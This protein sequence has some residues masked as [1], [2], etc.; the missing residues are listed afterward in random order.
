MT[1]DFQ[2]TLFITATV[3][4]GAKDPFIALEPTS[5]IPVSF[6]PGSLSLKLKEGTSIE[7]AQRL[8]KAL[9]E[10]VTGITHLPKA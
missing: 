4:E 3:K 9:R 2:E 7:E 5:S 6:A 1:A 8:A 10:L